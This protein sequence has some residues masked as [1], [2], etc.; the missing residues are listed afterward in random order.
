MLVSLSSHMA[1]SFLRILCLL[2]HL[3]CS[4]F[5][6]SSRWCKQDERDGDIRIAWPNHV[7]HYLPEIGWRGAQ[8]F[9]PSTWHREQRAITYDSNPA[10]RHVVTTQSRLR[11]FWMFFCCFFLIAFLPLA[12]EV[13]AL[14]SLIHKT[15]TMLWCN[16]I[17]SKWTVVTWSRKADQALVQTVKVGNTTC[18]RVEND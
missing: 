10:R 18:T 9:Y 4:C 3:L 7:I 1:A 15:Q 5:Q 13:H 12:N 2:R 16:F 6:K 11:W 17:I 14:R 8:A